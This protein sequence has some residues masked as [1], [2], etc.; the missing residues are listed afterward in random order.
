NPHKIVGRRDRPSYLRWLRDL[1]QLLPHRIEVVEVVARDDPDRAAAVLHD[2]IHKHIRLAQVGLK[3]KYLPA[4]RALV[5][6]VQPVGVDGT[7]EQ[8][9]IILKNL[10]Q[11]VAIAVVGVRNGYMMKNK[12]SGLDPYLQQSLVARQ[13]EVSLAVG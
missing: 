11:A 3:R 5:E 10:G 12:F 9:L 2:V 6:Q 7:Q 13:P 8:V 4:S 1:H